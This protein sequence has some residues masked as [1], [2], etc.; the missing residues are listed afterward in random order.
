MSFPSITIDE[1]KKVLRQAA[2]RDY[3]KFAR[4]REGCESLRGVEVPDE[5][6]AAAALLEDYAAVHSRPMVHMITG[7]GCDVDLRRALDR[8][9][10]SESVEWARSLFGTVLRFVDPNGKIW[11]VDCLPSHLVP[12]EMSA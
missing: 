3:G 6:R 2:W 4:L 7:F 9:D 5:V 1:A 12:E 11:A 8:A 10:A